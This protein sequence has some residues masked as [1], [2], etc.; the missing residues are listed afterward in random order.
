[1]Q[2]RSLGCPENLSSVYSHL[3]LKLDEKS[4]NF[5]FQL[6]LKTKEYDVGSFAKNLSDLKPDNFVHN[7]TIRRDKF[8]DN[9]AFQLDK[10][11]CV[12]EILLD[13]PSSVSIPN[14]KPDKIIVE[15]SSPNIAKPFHVGHLR[16]TILGNYVAN[17]N[18]FL[19]NDVRRINYLGDWGTQFGFVQLGIDL[20]NVSDDSMQR[21]PI[22]VLY[23]A[24]VHANKLAETDPSIADKARK[25]FNDLEEGR[26]SDFGKWETFRRFTVDE[27]K[28]TYERLGVNFDEYNWESEYNRKKISPVI[29][30]M[31]SL[32]ILDTDKEDRRVIAISEK[33]NIPI[34]KSDGST[35]YITRDI[36]AAMDRFEK[37][38]FDFMYYIVDNGQTDHFTSLSKIL[39]KM[40]FPWAGKIGHVKFGR[41]RNMSTRKGS[42]VFLKDILDETRTVM[43]ENQIRSPSKAP[44]TRSESFPNNK[45]LRYIFQTLRCSSTRTNSLPTCSASPLLL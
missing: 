39:E 18:Q 6:P 43:R 30:L 5:Y 3:D 2:I 33:R 31:E 11:H 8:G 28:R 38:K 32:G 4:E 15:Y 27:L 24:Y 9:I 16:S 25:I 10:D 7:V 23:D 12:K 34:I 45:L 29:D 41:I 44:A 35:L 1:M 20:L 37:H 26:D 22:R 19:L 42:A 21:D 14:D 40:E 36:A 13:D 17:V